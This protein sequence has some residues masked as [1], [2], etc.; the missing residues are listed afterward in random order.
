MIEKTIAQQEK[1][2]KKYDRIIGKRLFTK[3]QVMEI[4]QRVWE[5][6]YDYEMGVENPYDHELL[7]NNPL[8]RSLIPK[9]IDPLEEW[10]EADRAL[11]NEE[12]NEEKEITCL[13]DELDQK[14]TDEMKRFGL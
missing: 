12:R 13:R 7:A 10:E 9:L 4:V 5:T 1:K 11:A 6:T 3:E 8:I 14:L 2:L